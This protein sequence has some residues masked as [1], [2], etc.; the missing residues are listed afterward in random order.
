MTVWTARPTPS[1][2]RLILPPMTVKG[3]PTSWKMKD[4]CGR[5]GSE[6]FEDTRDT[7]GK[8]VRKEAENKLGGAL[9]GEKRLICRLVVLIAGMD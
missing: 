6:N 2:A 3:R 5:S 1:C 8:E 7:I 9:R 4:I